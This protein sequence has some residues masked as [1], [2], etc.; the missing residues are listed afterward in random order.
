MKLEHATEM[1][2]LGEEMAPGFSWLDP[3]QP[4]LVERYEARVEELETE[5]K[6]PYSLY[7]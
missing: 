5:I 7:I 1:Q 3:S 4:A 6:E 2:R